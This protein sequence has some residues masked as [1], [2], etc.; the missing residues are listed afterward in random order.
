MGF[1]QDVIN[2]VKM[3]IET[4][5]RIICFLNSVPRRIANLNAGFESIFNGTNVVEE[6]FAERSIDAQ[7]ARKTP[8][9]L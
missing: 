6:A 3:M 7:V 8:T 1:I 5:K 9:W 2:G 4:F